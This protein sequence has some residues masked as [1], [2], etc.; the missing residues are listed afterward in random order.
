MADARY[1]WEN[2]KGLVLGAALALVLALP[3]LRFKA[4]HLGESHRRLQFL[5]SYLLRTDLSLHDKARQ[6]AETYV[7]SLSPVY[8]CAPDNGRD[9][10][11]H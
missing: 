7:A 9:L 11:R 4:G 6:F 2:R 8:G 10:I 5:D 1:H 3:N